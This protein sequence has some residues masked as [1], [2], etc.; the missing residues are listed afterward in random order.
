[1]VLMGYVT[2]EDSGE[3]TRIIFLSV[4]SILRQIAMR[5]EHLIHAKV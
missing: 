3:L 1:M 2:W 4:D 5:N